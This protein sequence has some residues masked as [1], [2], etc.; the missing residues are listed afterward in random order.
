MQGDFYYFYFARCLRSYTLATTP[1]WLMWMLLPGTLK[2]FF[3]IYI[4]IY[5]QYIF[6]EFLVL[7]YWR[8]HFFATVQCRLLYGDFMYQAPYSL[9]L[10]VY[11]LFFGS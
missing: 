9:G 4:Y 3:Y 11:K 1:G 2:S 10:R 8:Y 7:F 5:L 6:S